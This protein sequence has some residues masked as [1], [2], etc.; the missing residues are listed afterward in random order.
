MSDRVRPNRNTLANRMSTCVR[1][2]S[3]NSLL[4]LSIRLM[5][6]V[7][8]GTVNPKP[9]WPSAA[10]ITE[11]GTCQVA[12]NCDGGCERTVALMSTSIFGTV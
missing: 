4:L 1:R 8:V 9:V 5:F 12:V 7:A 10:L 11:F 6:V 3:T 2:L